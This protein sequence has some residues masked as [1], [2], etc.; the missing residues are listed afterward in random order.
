MS[1]NRYVDRFVETL[2]ENGLETYNRDTKE[3]E[4]LGGAKLYFYP[5]WKKA[6]SGIIINN[7]HFASIISQFPA[8]LYSLSRVK[9]KDGKPV[10]LPDNKGYDRTCIG[11]MLYHTYDEDTTCGESMRD[12]IIAGMQKFAKLD[13]YVDVLNHCSPLAMSRAERALSTFSVRDPMQNFT[14][15]KLHA[16]V[17]LALASGAPGSTALW[18]SENKRAANRTAMSQGTTAGQEE[19]ENLPF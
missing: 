5:Q 1:K 3:N 16:A 4:N 18:T 7:P 11:L 13:T 14:T 10:I 19:Q 2:F 15:F 9:T 12:S 17:I 8:T 6:G